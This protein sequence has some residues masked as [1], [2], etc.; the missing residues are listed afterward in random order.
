MV[1]RGFLRSLWWF[2][3]MLLAVGSSLAA[4]VTVTTDRDQVALN[5]TFQLVFTVQ[6]E[7]TGEPDF[8]PLN[9]DFQLLGTSS[10]SQISM[11]NGNTSRSKVYTLRVAPKRAGELVLPPIDF[12]SDQSNPGSIR[13]LETAA[14]MDDMP[15]VEN[16]LRV[17]ASVD[18]AEPYVQQQVL[19]TVKIYR[20][21][22]WQQ[23]ALSELDAGSSDLLVQQLGEDKHYRTTLE[24]RSWEVVERKFA[25]FPQQSGEL[26]ISPFTLT[27]A[28]ADNSQPQGRRSN[29]PFDRF[30][31][32]RSTVQKTARSN[33]IKLQVKPVPAGVHPWLAASDLK[34]QENWSVDT[35]NLQTGESVTRTIAIIA[36]GVS[37]GQLPQLEPAEVAGIKS[38]PDQPQTNEQATSRGLLSTSSRKFALIPN[39][40]GEFEI[41]ALEINW[42]NVNADRM[43][44]ARLPGRRIKVSGAVVPAV[45]T[46]PPIQVQEPVSTEG[47]PIELAPAPVSKA[48]NWLVFSNV[49]LLVLWLITLFA[50]WRARKTAQQLPAGKVTKEPQATRRGLFKALDKAAADK[51]GGAA[52]DA[53]LQCAQYIW[54]DDAP[55]SLA[56]VARRSNG[57]LADELNN[58]ERSLYGADQ[59]N[60]DGGIIARELSGM[61]QQKIKQESLTT[62]L[63]PMYPA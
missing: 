44:V 49:I 57:K 29:D 53:I 17:V 23:A 47:Q 3:L 46:A 10:S 48:G 55:A 33:A 20:S 58:L 39:R 38:Y 40:G 60:W 12:G 18:A 22:N 32:R 26:E 16:E 43:E 61:K 37:V 27:A 8:S 36:D 15:G 1:S 41:P 30:F 6:G 19:L 52:R 5:E 7:Q 51:D 25:L 56:E 42:W 62:A 35:D 24:G 28:V 2:G 21:I 54:Q 59:T 31:S 9:K 13:V 45:E 50:W 14:A 34:L 4:T 63:K 11:V